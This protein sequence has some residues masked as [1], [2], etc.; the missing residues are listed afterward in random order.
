MP[1]Y[2]LLRNNKESGPYSLNDLVTL[3]LKP[4]DLVWIEGRSAAWRYPSEI[5][6]LK[7]YAPVVEEQ[8]YD[9]FFKKPSETE[10]KEEF[11]P[12]RQEVVPEKKFIKEEPVKR[13]VVE[14]NNC[15]PSYSAQTKKIFVSLPEKNNTINGYNNQGN[16]DNSYKQ[17][18]PRA[19]QEEQPKPAEQRTYSPI[20]IQESDETRLETKYT[21]SLDEIKEM[22]VNTLVQRKTRNRRKELV[23]KYMKPVL[24]SLF[25]LLCGAVIGYILTSKKT[26]LQA[27]EAIS[28]IIPQQKSEQVPA[29]KNEILQPEE[30]QA[31]VPQPENKNKQGQSQQTA[32]VQTK[33]TGTRSLLPNNQSSLKPFADDKNKSAPVQ[34][35]QVA[36]IPKQDVETDPQTGERRKVTR[37]DEGNE[38]LAEPKEQKTEERPAR[39]SN[40][41]E[42]KSLN[43][44][45]SVK[46]NDYIRG[47]FGG[48]RDLKL[49]VSNNSKYFVDEVKV[50][51]QYIKPSQLPLRTDIITF[52]NLSPNGSV[53]IKV[54]DS[55]R[56]MRVDYRVTR[57]QS[58]D[59]ERGT[60]G[61]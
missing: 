32:Q 55:Q 58:R 1:S 48:I 22:Y 43:K 3:G 52:R 7:D 47:T 35:D 15:Q 41:A 20:N 60:A 39:S 18:Q 5:S 38:T 53:T 14:T 9:R 50:E 4:Y 25:L 6:E 57:V 37:N 17:Y 61:L 19:I 54:P 13:I 12:E 2:L 21:Q 24:A 10:V 27:T 31:I 36:N 8:P 59:W 26:S 29:D 51:L 34:D 28:T 23:K 42:P 33:K 46:T 40:A 30:K 45:V 11:V 49:T 56:G 44:L 16:A